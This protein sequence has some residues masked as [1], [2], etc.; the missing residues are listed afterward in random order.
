MLI[1]IAWWEVMKNKITAEKYF[2][3]RLAIND[4]LKFIWSCHFYNLVSF[5]PLIWIC[6][7]CPWVE[8]WQLVWEEV[9][10]SCGRWKNT[11]H[12][13]ILF[14]EKLQQLKNYTATLFVFLYFLKTHFHRPSNLLIRLFINFKITS[15]NRDFAKIYWIKKN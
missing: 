13:V 7:I 4:M 10:N 1:R 14:V 5:N 2:S 3:F 11:D 9:F 12:G 15:K 6:P 8:C